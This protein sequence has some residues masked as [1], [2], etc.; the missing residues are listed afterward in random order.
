MANAGVVGAGYWWCAVAVGLTVG[1]SVR[2]KSTR[3]FMARTCRMQL[4]WQ[5]AFERAM[6]LIGLC[7]SHSLHSR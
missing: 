4:N 7:A 2:A 6:I 1:D 3:A 5:N